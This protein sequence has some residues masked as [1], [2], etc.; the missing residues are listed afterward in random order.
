MNFYQYFTIRSGFFFLAFFTLI[1]LSVVVSSSSDPDD[2][3]SSHFM[4]SNPALASGD[5]DI[6]NNGQADA[7]TDGL[8][9]LRYAFGLTGDALVSGVVASDAQYTTASDIE[10]ELATVYDSSGD[11]DGNGSVDALSDGLLVLRYLFGLDGDTLTAGVIGSGATVTDSAAL[12]TYLSTLMPQAP[13]I[14]LNGSVTI[15]H[16]QATSY[17]D[18]G[19]TATD[20]IDGSVTVTTIGLVDSD[21]AGIYTSSYSATDSEGNVSRVLTR[22]VT[23]ADTITPVITLVGDATLD[24]EQDSTYTDAGATAVDAVD[25]SITVITAGSVDTATPGTYILS[26]TATDNAGNQATVTRS[27]TVTSSKFVVDVFANGEVDPI[28]DDGM[29]AADSEIDWSSCNNGGNDCPNISWEIV[30]DSER[31]GVVQIEHSSA[32]KQ[33]IFYFKASSGQDL[34]GYAGGELIFDIKTITGDSNYSIKVDCIHPCSSGD[35]S[36]GLRGNSGWETVIIK[37]DTLVDAGLSLATVDTGIVI[38]ATEYTD[39]VFQLDNVRWEDTDISDGTDPVDPVSGDD[40]W[41]I[42]SFSGY[43]SPNSYTDYDLVWSDEFDGSALNTSDWTFEIGTG[44]DGWGNNELQ[45]YTNRNLYLKDGVM[46][47]RADEESFRGRSYTSSRIKTQGN[48]NFQYGRIDIRAR[49]PEGQGIWPALWMLGKNINEVSWPYCGEVDIMEMVGGGS[50]KDNR[51]V[52]T[53]H[54]NAG[55]LNASYSPA[56]FGNP[57]LMP[58]NLSNNFHV[59]SI[60]WD[61]NRIKWYIDDVQYHI[62]SI[63]NSASLEAFQKEFF[64]IFNLAVGGQWPGNPDTSTVFPQRLLVDYV[65]VFQD[66]NGNSSG[67]SG[68]THPV[69]GLIEAEDYTDMSG[70]QIETTTDTG[71]GSNVGYIDTGDWLEFS[72]DVADEGSYLIEYRVASKVGSNGFQT[73]IDGTLI[74]TQ[75][76][77]NTGGWQSWTTNSVI[78][79]LNSGEHT[80]RL[81][82]IGNEWNLNW[83]NFTVHEESVAKPVN[84]SKWFHQTQLPNGNSWYNG[85]QQHYTDRIENASVANGI[86]SITAKKESFED[87]GVT[88]Q[89]TSA[90]LNSKFAFTYGRVEVRAKI[91]EGQG[92]WPAIWMLSKDI[93]EPGAYFA[94]DFGTTSWPDGG[95]IDILEHWGGNPNYAQSA[96]HTRSSFGGTINHGGQSIPTMT[97]DF[98]IYSLDWS[99]E[100]MVFKVDGVE[101]YTYKPETK[102]NETWPFDRDQY[103]LLN[104]AIEDSIYQGFEEDNL[105]VDFVRIYGENNNLI[106]SDEFD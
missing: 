99:A 28:W 6:D 23:V 94:E 60:V 7:L 37:V 74:D 20:F 53:A 14:I 9:F 81:N 91:P 61:S 104:F 18:A 16:E 48:Q 26:Y 39:T 44:N 66:E 85:E 79:N 102:N 57:K 3:A 49:M 103:L 86:L 59:Y 41:V 19:A 73:L 13:Y 47:I 10:Q 100:K 29:N 2:N 40:G 69:P 84:S 34:S 70:I 105:N 106:W 54:W 24:V 22:T 21:T 27:I 25:G 58:E 51:V 82:A 50:G 96:I 35:Q 32:N 67:Q 55:G 98:H 64:L 1:L 45:Y 30:Q 8:L 92:T 89:Y 87:Q 97:S 78:V 65:R 83:I 56:S 72:L 12:E 68:T 31:G 11:I 43:Q 4:M 46:V 33:A 77:Q 76:V 42:P 88:K 52:G 90:R 17:V 71:G 80:L 62:M 38:W 15:N 93:N 95:E 36:M 101:H 75:G 63:D 5:W